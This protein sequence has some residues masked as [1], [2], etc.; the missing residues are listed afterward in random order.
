[1]FDEKFWVAAAF[2]LF[3]LLIVKPFKKLVIA[4]LDKKRDDMEYDIK[5]SEDVK[6]EAEDMLSFY[7]KKQNEII[8][9]SLKIIED[10]KIE[11]SKIRQEAESSLEEYI[12]RKMASSAAK[13]EQLEQKML[14][15][16]HEKTLAAAF[17]IVENYLSNNN[18]E[19]IDY[20]SIKNAAYIINKKIH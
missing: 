15:E 2:V 18:S 16:F 17:N 11:A 20:E 1:M 13:I 4:K 8:N 5:S 6:K 14:Q 19:D 7:K 12:N 10:A 9:Q 3:I